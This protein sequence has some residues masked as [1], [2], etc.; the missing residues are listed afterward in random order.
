MANGCC[1]SNTLCAD[2]ENQ[3]RLARLREELL[4]NFNS[5]LLDR[6]RFLE[7][8]INQ[9]SSV[10]ST[11]AAITTT[12]TTTTASKCTRTPSATN[13]RLS[14]P[15]PLRR[16]SSTTAYFLQSPSDQNSSSTNGEGARS[17][18][19]SVDLSSSNDQ[20]RRFFASKFFS[21]S[22]NRR[23][24]E[25]HSN[26]LSIPFDAQSSTLNNDSATNTN[27]N[28]E[29]GRLESRRF[30]CD[31]ND[32]EVRAFKAMVYMGQARK[33]HARPLTRLRQALGI[34]T[35]SHPVN[36]ASSSSKKQSNT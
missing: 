17:C 30:A 34:S 20:R 33:Q 18:P 22:T 3:L 6:I 36:Y 28:N 24:T 16:S 11:P 23:S 10:P 19:S 4:T 26:Y 2:R 27:V 31:V 32:N 1:C 14:V 8:T 13:E 12:T 21:Q 15:P 9:L 7:Q 29:K 35:H 25:N 5:L